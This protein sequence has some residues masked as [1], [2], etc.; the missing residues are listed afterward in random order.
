MFTINGLGLLVHELPQVMDLC[1]LALQDAQHL[2]ALLL[3]LVRL[4]GQL[5]L[6]NLVQIRNFL[7][8]LRDERLQITD[9]ARLQLQLRLEALDVVS[10]S[11]RGAQ[12]PSRGSR[13]RPLG[14]RIIKP[15]AHRQGKLN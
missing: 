12:L 15:R 2:G 11:P 1:V 4:D 14:G 3:V 9:S 13:A 10:I 5:A 7:L 8:T 6:Q